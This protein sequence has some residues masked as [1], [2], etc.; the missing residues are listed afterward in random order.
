MLGMFLYIETLNMLWSSE[1]HSHLSF[2]FILF[3]VL[4][5]HFLYLLVLSSCHSSSIL[6][7]WIILL[8]FLMFRT[9]FT[10][11]LL[12]FLL[13]ILISFLI[14]SILILLPLILPSSWRLITLSRAFAIL[15]WF[16]ALQLATFLSFEFS[17]LFSYLHDNNSISVLFCISVNTFLFF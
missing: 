14:F 17:W 11:L 10:F 16:L 5:F 6:N 13:I 4:F 9:L 12:C 15:L 1:R 8:P 3:T 2:L 7:F